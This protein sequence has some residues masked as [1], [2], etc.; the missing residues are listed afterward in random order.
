METRPP[1]WDIGHHRLLLAR[2]PQAA[3]RN[4]YTRLDRWRL[5]DGWTL[6]LYERSS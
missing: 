2:G 4:G 1:H 3:L 6:A 5:P